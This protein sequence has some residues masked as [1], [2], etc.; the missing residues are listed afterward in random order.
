M[1]NEKDQKEIRV[2]AKYL[3]RA[4]GNR[5]YLEFAIKELFKG[6]AEV[7]SD[8]QGQ[9]V[10]YTGHSYGLCSGDVTCMETKEF[11]DS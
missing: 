4:M 3:R 11:L 2:L 1:P 7:S 10:V 6:K 8:N 9:L 5:Q